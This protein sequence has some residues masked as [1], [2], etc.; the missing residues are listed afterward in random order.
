MEKFNPK[1][2]KSD[3]KFKTNLKVS[4]TKKSLKPLLASMLKTNKIDSGKI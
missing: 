3:F 4:G 1:F 2:I